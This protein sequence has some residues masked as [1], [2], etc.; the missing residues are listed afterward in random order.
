MKKAVA[1]IL[2]VLSAPP[3]FAQ[4]EYIGVRVREWYAKME[5][6]IKAGGNVPG[7]TTINLASDLGLD[8]SEWNTEVQV[9]GRIPFF[10]KIYAGWWMVD[11]QGDEILS[12]TISFAN[13]SF[14][15]STEVK[16]EASL[17]VGYLTYEFDFPAIPI[18]DLL[19]WELGLQVGARVMR[20]EG[21]IDSALVSGSDGGTIGIPVVGGHAAVQITP[22]LRADAEVVGLDFSYSGHR[23]SYFEA[24]GEV[25]AQPFS[26]LFAGVG[27]KYVSLGVRTHLSSSDFELDS[28]ITGLYVTAGVRF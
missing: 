18:G 20:G 9:Y 22:Y 2:V 15:A 21:K 8:S 4:D 11:R 26:W 1:A 24:Y 19:K 10:G 14:T 5:G 3:A 7:D 13:Q 6:D 27:Y 28:H 17:E 25:V 12:R 16:T 23:G